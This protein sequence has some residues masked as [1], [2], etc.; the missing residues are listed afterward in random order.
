MRE[1]EQQG[2]STYA[3]LFAVKYEKLDSMEASLSCRKTKISRE[4]QEGQIPPCE[5]GGL[6]QR[7]SPATQGMADYR[8]L[9]VQTH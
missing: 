3:P 1:R 8:D 4:L 2:E 5:H 9:A 7:R 6:R